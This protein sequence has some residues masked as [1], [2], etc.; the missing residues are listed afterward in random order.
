MSNDSI[1]DPSRVPSQSAGINRQLIKLLVPTVPY[2]IKKFGTN[3]K[4]YNSNPVK[5]KWSDIK[6]WY[7]DQIIDNIT[8]SYI[9]NLKDIVIKKVSYSPIDY[10]K[11]PTTCIRGT[12]S[13]GAVFHISQDQCVLSPQLGN[14]KIPSLENVYLCG[15]ANYPGPGVSMASGRNADTSYTKGFM[16]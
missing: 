16:N 13:C 11:R 3:Y 5:I 10:E 8:Y 1:M 15:S 7:A 14:Y 9:L 2:D 6:Q 12:L 4:D